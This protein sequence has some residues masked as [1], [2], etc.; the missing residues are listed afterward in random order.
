MKVPNKILG[1]NKD[2]TLERYLC[3]DGSG[4]EDAAGSSTLNPTL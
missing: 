4:F 1:L 3:F 2:P